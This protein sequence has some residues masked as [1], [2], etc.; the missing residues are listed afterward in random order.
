MGPQSS[1]P[2][3]VEDK[4]DSP[5]KKSLIPGAV[6]SEVKGIQSDHQGG[7]EYFQKLGVLWS[8]GPGGAGRKQAGARGLRQL[9]AGS[10]AW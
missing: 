4:G 1:I 7:V 5:G 8:E 10:S 6:L 3:R 2:V 9:G